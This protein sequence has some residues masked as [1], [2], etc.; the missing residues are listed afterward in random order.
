M[1]IIIGLFF[2][3]V[4][5]GCSSNPI[6]TLTTWLNDNDES[7]VIVRVATANAIYA[8]G[9]RE[10]CPR[11]FRAAEIVSEARAVINNDVLTLSVIDKQLS[12]IIAKSGIDPITASIL[13]D[14]GTGI[15]ID[16]ANM[17]EAGVMSEDAKI[18][19]NALLDAVNTV[20]SIASA[21]C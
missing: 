4:L 15:V 21:E 5:A 19:I 13:L 18:T 3:F 9:P 16:H 14:V 10:I 17:V 7:M 1:K 2:V 6:N 12:K 20:A 11:A 8:N